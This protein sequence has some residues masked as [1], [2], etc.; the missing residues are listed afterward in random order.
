MG[1]GDTGHSGGKPGAPS[2]GSAAVAGS[3]GSESGAASDAG[4]SS[5]QGGDASA[6][7]QGQGDSDAGA[8]G[9][10]AEPEPVDPIE[11]VRGKVPN[12]LDLLMMIDN[13]ISMANKQHLLADAMQHLV[14]RL[15]QPR[16]LDE[17]GAATGERA[18]P[19]GACPGGSHPEF[20]PFNDI[21]AAVVTSSLGAHG[22]TGANDVCVAPDDD[23][24]AELLGSIRPGLPSWNGTG[25]L[26][27]DPKQALTPVGI[28]DPQ[29]FASALA[30]TVEAAGDTGC[31]FEA[32][33]EAWY[34]FLI[35]PEPPQAVV[36]TDNRASVQGVNQNVLAARDAFLRS[37]SVLAI[38][39]L[40]DEN[41]CSIIDDGYGW[42]LTRQ[43]PMF[44]STSACLTNPND[45]CC[46]SCGEA[47]ARQGCPAPTEDVECQKG[48]F[49]VTSDEDALGLRCYEQKRRFGFD[50]LQP[51]QRYI[52]GLTS[53]EVE[54]RS[55]GALVPNPIFVSRGG[56]A[57]RSPEQVLLLGIVGVPWQ[58][59]A[60]A[61]SLTGPGLRFLSEQG[62]LDSERWAAIL[63]DPHQSPP[64]LPLDPF[65][66]ESV[67]D[68][69]TLD[70]PD[71]NPFVPSA[72][73]VPATSTDPQANVINGHESAS[74]EKN[75]LQYACTFELPAPVTCD[76][77]ALDAGRACDCFELDL[78]ANR[79]L[80]QPKGGGATGTIQYFGQVYPG[81]RQ[82]EVLKGVAGHGI[83]ASACP[84]TAELSSPSYGYRPAMDALAGRVARQIGRSCLSLDAGADADGRTACSL[85]TASI[86]PSCSCPSEQGLSDAPAEVAEP[87]RQKL[88]SVGYCGGA[89]P[90][91]SLCLCELTQHDGSDLA[92]CQNADAAPDA[93]GFCYLNAVSGETHAGKAE[94]ARDCVGPAPRRIRFTGGAPG[95][96]LALLYCPQ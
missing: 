83:V 45:A 66:I 52:D 58:D 61:S 7:D 60:E 80:C 19:G 81:L 38:V 94:L 32:S 67:E 5:A 18:S 62:Q 13:S 96:S 59:V 28:G 40:S 24:H 71:A 56:A 11:L 50:L 68:R 37:D 6:G 90:C 87:L 51:V 95:N 54:R 3:A 91:D 47:T 82:L 16:C 20:L 46:Q 72:K 4:G 75:D 36:V 64:L 93:P 88:E 27:W 1:C 26:V 78:P 2:G 74:P 57:P 42:L 25:F 49:L 79:A 39:M 8:A 63:G 9:A 34:R 33:L 77:A 12:K 31:G 23:D 29:E 48:R 85:Y 14:E 44:R 84:K 73:L 22:S 43:S 76:Q 17:K 70:V 55:D 89:T 69:T 92:A 65:M 15:I 53:S 86:A 41:D 30:E 21:H 10:A 35:D